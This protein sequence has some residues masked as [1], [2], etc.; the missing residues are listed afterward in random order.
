MLSSPPAETWRSSKKK[1][2]APAQLQRIISHYGTTHVHTSPD[3]CGGESACALSLSLSLSL[4]HCAPEEGLGA[5]PAST[6]AAV[7][8]VAFCLAAEAQ[9]FPHLSFCFA[10]A[11]CSDASNTSSTS[12]KSVLYLE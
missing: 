8:T 12:Q 7:I 6:A 1:D 4:P 2:I 3:E 11:R 9:M 10:S 5:A